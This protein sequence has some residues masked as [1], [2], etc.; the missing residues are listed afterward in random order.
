MRIITKYIEQLQIEQVAIDFFS[1][2]ISLTLLILFFMLAK[3]IAELIFNNTIA[4]S[5]SLSR[6]N[7][8][9]QKTLIKLLHNIMNYALYFVLIYWVLSILGVPISSLLAGAGLAGVAIGL[10]AQGFLSDVVNGFFILLENQYDVGDSI[11]IGTV[12]GNVSSVGIRTTQIRGID[13]TL[14]VIP[15]RNITIVS[16]KSHGDMRTQIDIP[17]YAHTDLEKMT[18]IIK[19]VS[20]ENLEKYSEIVGSPNVLGPRTNTTGQLVFRVDIF[21]QNGQQN[22]IYSDFFRFYQEALLANGIHLPTMNATTSQS[23]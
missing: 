2:L 6:Q 19:T 23:K 18:S 5:I 9:R 1:K 7:I 4:K 16:N 17:I 20:K 22:R 15:N 14:Y 21:V 13:G 11:E 3:R 12:S 8:A 10:G